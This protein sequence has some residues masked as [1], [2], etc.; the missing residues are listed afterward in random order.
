VLAA[1]LGPSAASGL[2]RRARGEHEGEVEPWHEAKSVS[3]EHTFGENI[4]DASVLRAEL[5]RMTEKVAWQ[6]REQDRMSGCLTVKVRYPDFETVSRQSSIPYTCY[7]DELIPVAHELFRQL[8]RTDRKVRLLGVRLSE[9]TSGARQ[10]NL[11]SDEERR[12][13]LYR[14]IDAVKDRFGRDALTRGGS[15]EG[16]AD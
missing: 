8:Y 14:A 3:T 1:R 9:L 11:F 2:Q 12:S 15:M 16:K 7:D 4:G 5:V 13:Q 10:S 6:L